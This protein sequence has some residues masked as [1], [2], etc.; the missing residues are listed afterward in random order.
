[1]KIDL[2]EKELKKR[3]T[4][5]YQWGQKQNNKLDKAS[6][7][8]Y[9]IRY[10]DELIKRLKNEFDQVEDFN[11]LFHYAINRWYN[12]RSAKAVEHFFS[13]FED[14]EPNIDKYDKLVDFKIQGINFDHKTSV[15][16]KGF[17]KDFNYC[18]NNKRELITWLYEN[19]SREGRKHFSNRLFVILYNTT[20]DNHWHLKSELSLLNNVIN[21]Y[22]TNF[23]PEDLVK[24]KL[25][26]GQQ[27][28]SDIIWVVK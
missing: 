5:P 10:F 9:K 2:Y 13:T 14:V 23:N 15:F 25:Q 17:N 22:V 18:I 24:L 19:Q 16:P 3:L 26:N 21:S 20:S 28:L 12:F 6:N 27:P 1:M 7:F 11:E 4:Y 8:I